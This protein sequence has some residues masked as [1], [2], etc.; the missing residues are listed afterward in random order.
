MNVLLEQ[1]HVQTASETALQIYKERGPEREKEKWD[2]GGKKAKGK[3]ENLP[4]D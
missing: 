3:V 2:Q 1:G 4:P